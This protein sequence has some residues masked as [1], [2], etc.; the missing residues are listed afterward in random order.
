MVLTRFKILHLQNHLYYYFINDVYL[1]SLNDFV[2]TDLENFRYTIL[3]IQ[4]ILLEV[5]QRRRLL[6]NKED[7]P[8]VI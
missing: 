4:L 3:K 2:A 1:S 5:E 6:Y 8:Q 7:R